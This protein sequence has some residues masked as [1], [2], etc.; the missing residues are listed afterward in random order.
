MSA[1]KEEKKFLHIH[2]GNLK[3]MGM[4]FS[5]HRTCLANFDS[6]RFNIIQKT[7]VWIYCVFWAFVIKFQF[8][9][10][11]RSVSLPHLASSSC[12]FSLY[13]LYSRPTCH[14]CV[15]LNSDLSIVHSYIMHLSPLSSV[16]T[17]RVNV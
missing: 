1:V 6:P 16:F 12:Y 5:Q 3:I 8:S 2:S 13:T 4:L 17:V 14:Y 9:H 10:P 7:A 15:P 11:N